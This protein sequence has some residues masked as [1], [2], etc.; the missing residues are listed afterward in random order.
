MGGAVGAIGALIPEMIRAFGWSYT[1]AGLIMAFG[2]A[3]F[4]LSTTAA[5]FVLPRFGVRA[6]LVTGLLLEVVGL[7]LFGA[8]SGVAITAVVYAFLGVGFGAMEVAGN[9]LAISMERDGRGQLMNLMHAAFAVGGVT[10]TWMTSWF[11]QSGGSWSLVFR[12]LGVLALLV[13]L[14]LLTRPALLVATTISG[15]KVKATYER[16]QSQPERGPTLLLVILISMAVYV[17]IELGMAAWMSEFVVAA[18]GGSVAQG[19]RIVSLYWIG[20]CCGRVGIGLLHQ[21]SRHAGVIVVL[22]GVSVIGLVI[23][24]PASGMAWVAGGAFLCGIGLS[25]L[26]PLLISLAGAEYSKHRSRSM[27]LSAASG[28]LGSMVFPLATTMVADAFGIRIGMVIYLGLAILLTG[29]CTA[30]FTMTRK[31]P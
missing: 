7:L 16:D 15:Q 23:T 18:V 5:G 2:S 3:S 31:R 17:G 19:V 11:L 24:V 13:G 28:G 25:A 12:L 1:H 20:L 26:Y 9:D 21:G 6:A 27:G 14:F 10:V 30:L 22:A 8:W 29:L 4:V